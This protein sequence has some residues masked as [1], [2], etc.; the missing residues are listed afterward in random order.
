MRGAGVMSSLWCWLLD[1]RSVKYGLSCVLYEWI[2]PSGGAF[3]VVRMRATDY[4]SRLRDFV[5]PMTT[6][7]ERT[8]QMKRARNGALGAAL[9][10]AGWCATVGAASGQASIRVDEILQAEQQWAE[11]IVAIGKAY[12]QHQDYQRVA[13]KAVDRLYG[14]AVT[15]VLFKPTKA[16]EREFRLT[17]DDAL[18]YFVGGKVHEDHGF[19]LQPWAKVRFENA[20][21]SID[22]D[23]ATA[24]GNYYFT[25]AKSGSEVKVDYT[26]EYF[27]GPYGRLLIS[28]HHSSLPYHTE[29]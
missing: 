6:T 15:P 3:T 13:A 16:A 8:T 25:D 24:M 22:G 1:P 29:H 2:R 7:T 20:G 17:R 27:R 19:A 18:S 10:C 14:Y 23:S 21:F 12:T 5:I 4:H 28:V 9:V 11:A 26:F